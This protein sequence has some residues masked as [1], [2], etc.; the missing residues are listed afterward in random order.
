M[1]VKVKICEQFFIFLFKSKF[2]QIFN[3]FKFLIILIQKFV[4]KTLNN[5]NLHPHHHRQ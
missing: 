5:F 3:N 4:I 2:C 1:W